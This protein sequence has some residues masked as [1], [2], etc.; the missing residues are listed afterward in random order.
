MLGRT[1]ARCRL[2][3]PLETSMPFRPAVS[4]TAIAC[5]AYMLASRYI[6]LLSF[7]IHVVSTRMQAN[8]LLDNDRWRMHCYMHP[9]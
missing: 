1:Y 6:F 7:I 5:Y 3:F 9:L 2:A 8:L 4:K